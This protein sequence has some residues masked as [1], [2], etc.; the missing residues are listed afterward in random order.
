MLHIYSSPYICTCS[1]VLLCISAVYYNRLF[2]VIWVFTYSF[3]GLCIVPLYT[4]RW[5][6]IVHHLPLPLSAEVKS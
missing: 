2:A 5:N 6:F 1:P 3:A 4:L